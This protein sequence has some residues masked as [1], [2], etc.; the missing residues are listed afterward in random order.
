MCCSLFRGGKLSHLGDR[1]V[2]IHGNVLLTELFFF[3]TDQQNQ[4][5]P[6]LIEHANL[7]MFSRVKSN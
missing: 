6:G 5:T 2:L 4:W 1:N 3:F 7:F